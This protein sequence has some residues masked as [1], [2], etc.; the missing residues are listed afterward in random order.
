MVFRV[1][2]KCINFT[3]C[4]DYDRNYG[5]RCP[6]TQNDNCRHSDLHDQLRQLCTPTIT[7]HNGQIIFNLK[8]RAKLGKKNSASFF[9]I[10]MTFYIP[11]RNLSERKDHQGN[12]S[13]HNWQQ[14][15]QT[16]TDC[17]CLSYI[18]TTN[19]HVHINLIINNNLYNKLI[20]III[21]YF[22]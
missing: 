9:K 14:F 3:W 15:H 4:S 22:T 21:L 11:H 19:V 5:V 20:T 16:C 12:H 10:K 8:L 1:L 18:P 17:S 7:I 6:C 13:L 2:K